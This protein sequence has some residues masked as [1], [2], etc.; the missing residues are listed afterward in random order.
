MNALIPRNIPNTAVEVLPDSDRYKCRFKVKSE[1]S[2]SLY[3]I[4]TIMQLDGG[5]V[6]VVA[7]SLTVSANISLQ[8]VLKVASLD[9]PSLNSLPRKQ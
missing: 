9:S 2:N 6:L 5:R 7:I 8:Q 1:S 4:L 3:L